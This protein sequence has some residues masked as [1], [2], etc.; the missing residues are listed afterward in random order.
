MADVLAQ[1]TT[2]QSVIV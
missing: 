2:S 1:V